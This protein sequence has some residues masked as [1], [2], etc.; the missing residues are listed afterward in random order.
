MNSDVR[1]FKES[2]LPEYIRFQWLSCDLFYAMDLF[3]KNAPGF[4][5][6]QVVWEH[7]MPSCGERQA[8]QRG[9]RWWTFGTWTSKITGAQ[10]EHVGTIGKRSNKKHRFPRHFCCNNMEGKRTAQCLHSM[11]LIRG[12]T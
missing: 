7:S 4:G 11:L 5:I 10:L 3:N 8:V 12:H 2:T 6:S 9:Q 1:W